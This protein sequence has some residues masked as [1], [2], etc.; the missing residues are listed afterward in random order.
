MRKQKVSLDSI[1]DNSDS[2]E[3]YKSPKKPITRSSQKQKKKRKIDKK[4]TKTIDESIP[5][6]LEENPSNSKK[7]IVLRKNNSKTPD[8]NN[9]KKK[10]KIDNNVENE[11]SKTASFFDMLDQTDLEV[12]TSNLEQSKVKKI[13][14]SKSQKEIKKN[15]KEM[16]KKYEEYKKTMKEILESSSDSDSVEVPTIKEFSKVKTHLNEIFF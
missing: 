12:E 13:T 5:S 6:Y 4:S 8:K 16:E 2:E 11:L 10:P 1:F 9:S 7:K 14:I 3:E 15:N